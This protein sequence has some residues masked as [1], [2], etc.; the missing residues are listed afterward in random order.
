VLVGETRSTGVLVDDHSQRI[1]LRPQGRMAADI[2][3]DFTYARKQPGI[4]QHWLAHAYAVLTRLSSF[5]K[6]PGCVGQ[7]PHR[8][9]SVVGRHTAELGAGQERCP[10]AQV[11]RT[12]SGKYPRRASAN[13]EDVYHLWFFR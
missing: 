11:R 13:N 1:D 4:I 10:R 12:E 9:W 2:V 3:N 5:A 8:N 7:G 6:Q